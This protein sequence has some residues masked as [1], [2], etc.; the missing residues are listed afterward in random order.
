VP[1]NGI[2]CPENRHLFHKS[3]NKISIERMWAASLSPGYVLNIRL[4]NPLFAVLAG[5]AARI[6]DIADPR[7]GARRCAR[8]LLRLNTRSSAATKRGEATSHW[9]E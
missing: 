5:K 9:Q 6:S 1:R 2:I 8:N 4:S 7:L 3:I